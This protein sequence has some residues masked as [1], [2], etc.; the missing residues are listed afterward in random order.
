MADSSKFPRPAATQIGRRQLLALGGGALAATALPG[1]VVPLTNH[2]SE[3]ARAAESNYRESLMR[4]RRRVVRPDGTEA[5]ESGTGTASRA[6][7]RW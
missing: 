5:T 6:M 4:L 7:P 1:C 2:Q 3:L